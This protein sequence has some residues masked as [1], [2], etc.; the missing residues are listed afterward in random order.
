MKCLEDLQK[1]IFQPDFNFEYFNDM[2]FEVNSSNGYG[3]S[4]GKIS[5]F[6][7][8]LVKVAE[9]INLQSVYADLVMHMRPS[10]RP[11]IPRK[12]NYVASLHALS[13]FDV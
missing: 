9:W 4:L 2:G 12:C 3:S 6:V 1:Q 13:W 8:R 11:G 5:Y 10:T 7:Q